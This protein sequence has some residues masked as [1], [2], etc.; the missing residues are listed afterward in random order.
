[1]GKR[2]SVINRIFRNSD[3][4]FDEHFLYVEVG[5]IE[6]WYIDGDKETVKSQSEE[7]GYCSSFEYD[8]ETNMFKIFDSNKQIIIPR[9]AVKSIRYVEL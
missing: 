2:Q 6:I 9:E 4:V 7:K 8:I 5:M 1:M 3:F